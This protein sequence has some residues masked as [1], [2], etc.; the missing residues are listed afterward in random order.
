MSF[1]NNVYQALRAKLEKLG[2]DPR[3]ASDEASDHAC[4]DDDEDVGP[5]KK[6]AKKLMV[7]PAGQSG[8]VKAIRMVDDMCKGMKVTCNPNVKYYSIN[9]KCNN[10][11]P[12]KE[13]QGS[14]SSPFSR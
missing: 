6:V 7:Y 1:R 2:L 3:Q 11:L 13:M 10:V 5:F 9:G 12:G 14:M 4:G 8:F